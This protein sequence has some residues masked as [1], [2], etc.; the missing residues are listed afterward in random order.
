[1]NQDRYLTDKI[2]TPQGDVFVLAVFDGHGKMGE[3]AAEIARE[4]TSNYLKRKL[5]EG[6]PT[7]RLQDALIEEVFRKAHQNIVKAYPRLDHGNWEGKDFY[8]IN[9]SEGQMDYVAEEYEF[10]FLQDFGTT[11]VVVLY[12]ESLNSLV[13]GSVGD[14]LACLGTKQEK[15]NQGPP[16]DSEKQFE[17]LSKQLNISDNVE[18]NN[19][20]E[21]HR[22]RT[23][24]KNTLLKDG[25]LQPNKSVYNWHQLAMTRALGHKFLQKYGVIPTPHITRFSVT[26]NDLIIV[27]ASDGL[28]DVIDHEQ[29]IQIAIQDPPQKASESLVQTAIK[30]WQILW[31]SPENDSE[32]A[33]NTT[34]VVLKLNDY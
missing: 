25:Y 29:V 34:V 13:V 18:D 8:L 17:Y 27:V 23:K 1:L 31:P 14:S 16:N 21:L 32:L 19:S 2:T 5:V 12:F 3:H 24:F 33:D 20:E 11:A 26:P 4:T 28:W 7:K 6:V 30:M 22:I 9:G 10:L 15:E